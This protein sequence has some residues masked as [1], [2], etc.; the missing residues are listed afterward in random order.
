MIKIHNIEEPS[1]PSGEYENVQDT[2]MNVLKEA[3]IEIEEN[4]I[5]AAQRLPARRVD[6]ET[7]S[8]LITFTLTRRYDRN[9]ILRLKKKQ[10]KDNQSFQRKYPKVFMTEDLT[11]LRQHMAYRLRKDDK[12]AVTW[13]IDG[14]IK[15]LKKDFKKDDKPDTI[16]TPYDLGKVGWSKEEIDEFIKTNLTKNKD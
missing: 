9:R 1:L 2:V 7:K 8:K 6:G 4:M 11:P 15:C 5:S 10:M 16:D 13:S 12:I 3:G 14:R